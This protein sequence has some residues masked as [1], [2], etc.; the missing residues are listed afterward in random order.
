MIDSGYF[1]EKRKLTHAE[2]AADI[3]RHLQVRQLLGRAI[4]VTERS[5]VLLSAVRRQWMKIIDALKREQS[6]TL[7]MAL[8]TEL[9]VQLEAMQELQF[10]SKDPER[11]PDADVYFVEAEEASKLPNDNY[12]TV[13]I[14]TDLENASNVVSRLKPGCVV[15]QY[16]RDEADV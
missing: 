10:T 1:V 13:Y 12:H 4:V 9:S 5:P 15:V 16:Q 8:K 3:A 14:C 11:F 6:R 7:N 2:I